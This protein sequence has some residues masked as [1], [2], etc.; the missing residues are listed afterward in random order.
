MFQKLFHYGTLIIITAALI[1]GGYFYWLHQK[2]HPSTDD[3]Y[4]QAHVV[5][6]AAQING[7]VQKVWVRNQEPVKKNQLL[8]TI[9]PKPFHIALEKAKADLQNTMQ[10]IQ[11]QQHAVSAANAVLIQR[12][13]QLTDTQKNYDRIITLVKKGFYAKSGGDNATR[14]L[15]VA[16]Q[17]V[18]AAQNQLAEAKAKLGKTGDQNAQI[19]AASAAVAQAELNLHYTK[20]YAPQAGQ[21][22]Q[23]TL[24]PGQTVTAYESLFSLVET[25]T[26]WAMA[27]LKETDLER[28]RIG[29]SAIIAVDMYPSHPFIG[30]VKSISPSS[31]SSFSLLPSEN[32]SGNWVKVTQ[33]FP[34]RI[35]IKQPD[36]KF[37]LR[38]GASCSVVINTTELKK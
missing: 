18:I 12:E 24:Q 5:N 26:W 1:I 11:A 37:P 21:L 7:R 25:H 33:R 30:V 20:I 17:A 6:V 22:A 28:V 32:A 2:M 27:N 34:V 16:K 13:A 31:G 23:F 29:Q 8:F 10:V 36:P 4:I 9:N 35:E 15:T 19:Q 3:A 38:I 14:Q